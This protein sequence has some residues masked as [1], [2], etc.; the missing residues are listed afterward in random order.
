MSG[1][2]RVRTVRRDAVARRRLAA[3]PV[4]LMLLAVP[5]GACGDGDGGPAPIPKPIVLTTLVG[6]WDG[7]VD[8]G[9]DP[10]SYGRSDMTTVLAADS[11]MSVAAVGASNYC[12]AAGT[13]SFK[14]GQY[15]STARDC[16][17]TLINATGALSNARIT[18]TWTANS[19]RTGSFTMTKR[20]TSP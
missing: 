12:P 15:T 16:T 3:L 9:E 11:T 14:D 4:L 17:N 20:R 2:T 8:G 13:W 10:N 6:T 7:T 5:L 1:E 19:G 18:G